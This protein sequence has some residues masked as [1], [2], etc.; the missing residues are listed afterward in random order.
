MR[1][2]RSPV[3]VAALF[4]AV[5]A[6]SAAAQAT[7]PAAFGSLAATGAS[8]G[9]PLW[10]IPLGDLAQ[11]RARP[12][13]SSS[14]RPPA[15]PVLAALAAPPVDRKPPSKPG[16]DHPLLTL[17]GTIVG[18][19]IEIGVFVDE[20]SHDVIRLRVGEAHDGWTLRSVSARAA[21]FHKP[22]RAATLVLAPPDAEANAASGAAA[23]L[24]HVIPAAAE[25]GAKRLPH[26]G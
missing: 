14:R 13:F 15:A 10:A 18:E 12:M 2:G 22:G 7:A 25:G 24:P 19:S 17:L 20:A 16:P 26:D 21:M 8:A 23:L 3:P 11:T 1:R 6:A 4:S 5:F 9:N